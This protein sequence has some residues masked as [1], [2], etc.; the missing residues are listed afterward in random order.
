MNIYFDLDGV[1]CNLLRAFCEHNDV[2]Y[3]EHLFQPGVEAWESVDKSAGDFWRTLS[4]VDFW[5][6]LPMYAYAED[7][8]EYAGFLAGREN[9]FIA[10]APSTPESLPGKVL[11][12]E[13]HLPRWMHKQF[14]FTKHKHL[15]AHNSILVDDREFNLTH[16]EKGVL[17]PRPWNGAPPVGCM[18][19][20]IQDNLSRL[21]E[22]SYHR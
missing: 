2:E 3:N 18:A 1:L 21:Y 4:D 9:V 22:M 11:W 20:F 12:I 13:R 16:F 19:T 6:T 10:S 17:I 5:A 7:V 8:V 15:L 14:V